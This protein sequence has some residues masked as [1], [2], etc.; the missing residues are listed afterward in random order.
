MNTRLQRVVSWKRVV[1]ACSIV[2]FGARGI[3][4]VKLHRD[5]SSHNQDS[6]AVPNADVIRL[7]HPTVRMTGSKTTA[8][9]ALEEPFGVQESSA[10]PE[11]LLAKQSHY[12]REKLTILSYGGAWL[13]KK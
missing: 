7:R 3:A 5:G 4:L 1:L 12:Y 10:V 11:F 6:G 13:I 8:G 2:Y 9:Q